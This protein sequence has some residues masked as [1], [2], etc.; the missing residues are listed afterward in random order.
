PPEIIVRSGWQLPI[1]AWRFA[2][3]THLLDRN[4]R[5]YF[6]PRERVV[7]IERRSRP[8]DHYATISNARV[9]VGPRPEV[10]RERRVHVPPVQVRARAI[11]RW[12]APE[13]RAQVERAQTRRPEFE[14]RNQQRIE[15]KPQ[16]REAQNKVIESNP[17]VRQRVDERTRGQPNRGEQ[18]AR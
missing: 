16:L 7:E 8:L 17:T 4:V 9:A 1:E 3:T 15:S 14:A 13:A 18:Q 10:L 2:P 5:R 11:G 6:V 12:T